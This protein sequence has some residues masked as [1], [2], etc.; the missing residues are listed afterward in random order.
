M[1]PKLCGFSTAW[2]Q[3]S[4]KLPYHGTQFCRFATPWKPG[5]HSVENLFFPPIPPLP[6]TLR[7]LGDR[8]L[9]WRK[10]LG[11]SLVSESSGILGAEWERVTVNGKD[12]PQEAGQ[13]QAES[14]VTSSDVVGFVDFG[15][16]VETCFVWEERAC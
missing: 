8:L 4:E 3:V 2:K 5:F 1:E 13:G 10:T 14:Q 12:F 16:I 15:G 7:T 11:I 9:G 6:S